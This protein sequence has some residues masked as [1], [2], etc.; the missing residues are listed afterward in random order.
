MRDLAAR[1]EPELQR[2]WRALHW[3]SGRIEVLLLRRLLQT[4]AEATERARLTLDMAI[5]IG[6]QPRFDEALLQL[7]NELVQ[8]LACSRVAVGIEKRG[9]IRLRA[10]SQAATV[11]RRSEFSASSR[12]NSS[13]RR[14]APTTS[15]TVC[16]RPAEISCPTRP[17]L[18]VLVK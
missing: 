12:A 10:L 5:S 1:A 17:S 11:E 18:P 4:R 6:E 14:R 3:G 16:S 13:A 8:R 2:L 9:R 7:A 15:S